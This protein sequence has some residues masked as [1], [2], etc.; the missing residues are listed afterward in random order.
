MQANAAYEPK[1]RGW[2]LKQVS[3]RRLMGWKEAVEAGAEV[4]GCSLQA[5]ERYL[6]KLT[7]SEGPLQILTDNFG[8]KQI[9]FKERLE[10]G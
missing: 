8:N 1:Y 6:R 7:S 9:A 3:Q 5:S 4:V 10:E 2:V